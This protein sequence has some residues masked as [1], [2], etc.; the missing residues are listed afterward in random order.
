MS[1]RGPRNPEKPARPDRHPVHNEGP[2]NSGN[3]ERTS[4]DSVS[5]GGPRNPG[6]PGGPGRDPISIQGPR[7]SENPG[8]P[9]KNPVG[10]ITGFG[11]DCSSGSQD[12]RIVEGTKTCESAAKGPFYKLWLTYPRVGQ[13]S[14]LSEFPDGWLKVFGVFFFFSKTGKAAIW[15]CVGLC[16]NSA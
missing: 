8:G 13:N 6:N 2:R 1:T 10:T 12:S 16:H 9:G 15:N 4:R 14:L 7:N 11:S 5:T 3:S